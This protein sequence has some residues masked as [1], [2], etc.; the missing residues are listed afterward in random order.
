MKRK[1]AIVIIV[2]ILSICLFFIGCKNTGR[3]EELEN[4]I[5]GLQEELSAKEDTITKLQQKSNKL[6]KELEEAV[7]EEESIT[8]ESKS[9]DEV[10]SDEENILISIIDNY[11]NAVEKED[12]DEQ[13]KYVSKYALDLVNMKEFEYKNSI[14]TESRTIDK[15]RPRIDII[16]GNEAEG[17]ISFTEHLVG[18]DGSE[19]DLITEGKIDLE[20]IDNEWKIVDY[21]RKNHL[22]SE[23]LYVFEDLKKTHK[24]ITISIEWILFSLFDEYVYIHITIINDTDMKLGTDAYSSTIIGPDRL[25]NEMISLTGELREIFPSA[26]AIGSLIYNWSNASTGDLTLYFGDI[27][28][29]DNYDDLIKDLTFEVDLTQAVRY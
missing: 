11:I 3:I 14:G 13:R 24:D 22:I 2:L 4:R 18:F 15:E 29:E 27:Y 5:I 23:A 10:T 20:K 25:Q 7:V 28:R 12:F 9:A 6:E 8:Q 26:I 19:Y 16:N 1:T 21:T 17:F